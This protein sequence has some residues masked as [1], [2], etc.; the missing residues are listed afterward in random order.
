MGLLFVAAV[1]G[2]SVGY[3]IGKKFGPKVLKNK[4]QIQTLSKLRDTMLPKLMNGEI[5]VSNK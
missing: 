3:F 1:V 4:E 2:D 5:V